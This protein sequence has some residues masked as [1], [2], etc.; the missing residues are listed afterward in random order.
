[1]PLT[2]YTPIPNK[3]GTSNPQFTLQN[4]DTMAQ[5]VNRA[6]VAAHEHTN[7]AILDGI[8]AIKVNQW[9]SNSGGG[10]G[11]AYIV[12][13]SQ[14][15][16]PDD[17]DLT[18]GATE[19]GTDGTA[20]I[21]AIL[22]TASAT[23]PL[24]I[25][26]DTRTSHT[27]I[28]IKSYTEIVFSAGCGWVLRNNSNKP[29][30][31]N[32]NPTFGAKTDKHIY[33]SGPGIINGNGYNNAFPQGAQTR[34]GTVGHNVA[35]ALYG[36]D[37][38]GIRDIT[39][40]NARQYSIAAFA[41]DWGVVENVTKDDHT[42][43]L[44]QDGIDII[45]CSN[46]YVNN[47][48]I[49]GGDDHMV[50]ASDGIT[51]YIDIPDG[52]DSTYYEGISRDC[53]N[54]VVSNIFFGGP[55]GG[56]I[57]N[58]INA[59]IRMLS[60]GYKLKNVSILN[61]T[62]KT[63]AYSFMAD[64]FFYAP[65]LA[66]KP[67]PGYFENILI[68]GWNVEVPDG[69]GP[70]DST[71][72][73]NFGGNWDGLTIK[74]VTRR[75]FDDPRPTIAFQ[76]ANGIYKNVEIDGY[77]AFDSTGN[78][79]SHV[80]VFKG[81]MES[82]NITNAQVKKNSYVADSLLTVGDLASAGEVNMNNIEVNG[83]GYAA[84]FLGNLKT[85]RFTN[86]KH[87]GAPAAIRTFTSN[88]AVMDVVGSNYVGAGAVNIE[89]FPSRRGDAFSTLPPLFALYSNPSIIFTYTAQALKNV[90]GVW[91]TGAT[92]VNGYN[93]KGISA[94]AIPANQ[95]GRLLMYAGD[96][97]A[98]SAFLMLSTINAETSYTNLSGVG[99]AIGGDGGIVQVTNGVA[100]QIVGL[101][102]I[103]GNAYGLY[104][105]GG[106]GE[107]KLQRSADGLTWV[108][109]YTFSITSKATLYPAIDVRKDNDFPG[110]LYYPQLQ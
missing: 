95:T 67:G 50:I 54:I 93:N 109:L 61:V 99:V 94:S 88:F 57:G 42:Y 68:D 11:S 45:G 20:A 96:S 23:N 36:V 41:S 63:N 3:T 107:L 37:N 69:S 70:V 43:H 44:H 108:D 22:N 65:S 76:D 106:S 47:C 83:I 66:E 89:K 13:L 7:K 16:V 39:V 90:G 9:D 72:H 84:Y 48:R 58:R 92:A 79:L 103:F 4:H 10:S 100:A 26:W 75:N 101:S 53:E 73:M 18:F 51:N 62:G 15:G 14:M 19:H 59:G 27:G 34:M 12:Y 33:I 85:L 98:S 56:P 32:Y 74:N 5:A 17:A 8:T 28:R 110:I 105:D 81:Y 2:A 49:F 86:V 60:M 25:F 104:R 97:N 77:K 82:L 35:I 1:M 80:L 87:K 64:N 52:I 29:S 55:T 102:V 24:K 71:G 46:V 31:Q 38:W 91:R 40:G 6:N 78:N 30:I 21:Q